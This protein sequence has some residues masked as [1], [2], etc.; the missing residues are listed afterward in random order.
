MM[1]FLQKCCR[2]QPGTKGPVCVE[3]S[4]WSEPVP[5]GESKANCRP[6]A[7]I[8]PKVPGPTKPSL[9][10]TCP[11]PV[12]NVPPALTTLTVLGEAARGSRRGLLGSLTGKGV[13]TWARSPWSAWS[14]SSD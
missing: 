7:S 5:E 4:Y 14:G 10:L 12:G 3:M 2:D 11:G 8:F 13:T 1:G 9:L 6:K